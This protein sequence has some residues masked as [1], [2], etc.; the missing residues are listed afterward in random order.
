MTAARD[1][2]ERIDALDVTLFDAVDTQS[3]EGDRLSWLAVQRAVRAK[4]GYTYLEIG[5]HLGGSIQQHLVDPRCL[6]I[7][8]I[9][10]RPLHHPDD[11]G[12]DNVYEGNS[13]ARM[14]DNL[15]RVAPGRLERIECFDAD[16]SDIDPAAIAA[17]PDFCFIDGEHTRAAVVSDFAFC[18][19]VCG[20]DAAICFHDDQVIAPAILRI[21]SDLK[22]R[23]VPFVA[24]KL[25]GVTFGIFLRDCPAA[26]DPFVVERSHEGVRWLR[27][28][29]FRP[30]MPAWLRPLA[31][32]MA[33]LLGT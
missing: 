9:D 27:R 14:L 5:S 19:R 18:L 30:W 17:P 13:T 21:V 6:R 10:R 12:P 25:P 7:V 22:A 8:S 32:R 11:R 28:Q 15:R 31:R 33:G 23:G 26:R 24:R 16:A 1:A 3:S 2:G 4:G 29:R 20:P